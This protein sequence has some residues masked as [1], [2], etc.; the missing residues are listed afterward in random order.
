M[1]EQTL[2]KALYINGLD[3]FTE[4]TF[5]V[6]NPA[7][8]EVIGYVPDGTAKE[9][10]LAVNAAHDAFNTWSK[11]TAYERAA[12]LD[13][14]FHAVEARLDEIALTMTK[15]QGKPFAEAK[16]EMQYANSFIKWYAEEAKR[17]YGEMIPA[18]AG[19]KRIMVQK[20]AVGVVAA[21]TPWNFPAA[22]ITRKVAP[23]LAAGCTVIIKPAEQTPLTALL[24]AEC[25]HEAGIPAGV[26]NIVTTQNPGEVVDVWMDDSRVKKVTFTGSTPVGKLLMKKAANTVKKVSLELGGLAPFIIA[27]DA[28]IKEAVKGVVQSKFRNAGQTCIC[29]NRIYVHESIAESFLEEFKEAVSSLKVGNGLSENVDIGPLIDEEAMKKVNS[30]LADAIGKGASLHE[31]PDELSDKGYFMKPAVLSNVTDDMICMQEETF[32]P[33]A[34]VSTFSNDDEAIQRANATP[35]GLAA[36]VYTQSLQKAFFFSE[37]LEYGIVGVNDGAPSVAQAPFGGMKESGLGREGSHYGL[38]EF[39]EVK[40]VSLQLL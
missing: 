9:A 30:H 36:Y 22:M 20:Q 11:T 29:A 6:H 40:Y 23:A 39:L 13:R 18:L 15:E 12:L 16:G 2:T 10:K 38:D 1:N 32:G 8:L 24:L 33:L 27:E 34:P 14:W 4:E 37:N 21:I 17:I 5:A 19:N 35:F 25:A 26:I 3:H 7:T 28:N 31:S